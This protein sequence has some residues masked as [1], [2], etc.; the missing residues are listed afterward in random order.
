MFF[1]DQYV[2]GVRGDSLHE[3]ANADDLEN[4]GVDWEGLADDD[5]LASNLGNNSRQEGTSSWIGRDGPPPVLNNVPVE[6]P[7]MPLSIPEVEGLYA[8]VLPHLSSYD[9]QSL[10]TRWILGLAYSRLCN[11]LF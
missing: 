7:D 9:D 6:S 3:D 10:V 8:H 5:L 2:N 1:F 4:Y 11:D